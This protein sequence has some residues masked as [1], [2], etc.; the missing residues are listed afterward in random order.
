MKIKIVL[1]I[2]AFSAMA[3]AQSPPFQFTVGPAQHTSCII[4]ASV[5]TYCFADDGPFV[6]IHGAAWLSMIGSGLAQ[7]VLTFNGRKPD[8]NGNIAPSNGDYLF[9]QLGSI[10][11]LMTSFNGRSGIVTSALGDYSFAQISGTAPVPASFGCAQF[12]FINS[13]TP[14]LVAGGCK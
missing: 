12:S 3:L 9:S 1:A 6:S 14:P 2:L 7:A 11:A 5:T 13:G 10:P 8:A 4:V